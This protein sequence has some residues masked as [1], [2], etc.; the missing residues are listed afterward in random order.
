MQGEKIDSIVA[1]DSET[2]SDSGRHFTISFIASNFLHERACR[3]AERIDPIY[4][5]KKRLSL[6]I[7]ETG[8]PWIA[9]C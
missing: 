8:C 1:I 5:S 7:L 6:F 4:T 2:V 9:T 3:N